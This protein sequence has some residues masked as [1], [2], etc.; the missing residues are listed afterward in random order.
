MVSFTHP[1]VTTDVRDV[2]EAE[3]RVR[4][5]EG[6]RLVQILLRHKARKAGLPA[7]AID[8]HGKVGCDLWE[9]S[10]SVDAGKARNNTTHLLREFRRV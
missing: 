1:N 4:T 7:D 3:A 10:R 8:E 6:K 9:E 2:L 5:G